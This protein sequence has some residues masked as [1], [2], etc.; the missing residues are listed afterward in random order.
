MKGIVTVSVM[1]SVQV[2]APTNG[3]SLIPGARTAATG[4]EAQWDSQHEA[5]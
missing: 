1:V 3:G 4:T 5:R 2:A